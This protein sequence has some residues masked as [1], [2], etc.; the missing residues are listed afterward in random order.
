MT[1]GGPGE[2][3]TLAERLR[4]SV[5]ETLG[6]AHP[7]A[8]ER[9]YLKRLA[10]SYNTVSFAA[11]ERSDVFTGGVSLLDVYV[12][13]SIDELQLVRQPAPKDKSRGQQD[14]EIVVTISEPVSLD[15]V[16][17]GNVV[18]S[19]TPGA[20]KSALSAGWP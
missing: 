4:V 3:D 20:G 7:K 16:L 13:L 5:I 6:H 2:L 9:E 12:P 8:A 11:F 19:G 10:L 15:A 1:Y 14:T 18:L 17:Q